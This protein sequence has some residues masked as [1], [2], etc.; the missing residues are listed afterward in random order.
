MS[1]IRLYKPTSNARRHA[2]V[3]T[4]S[5]VTAQR[6]HAS[7]TVF[8]KS[9]GGRNNQ[10]RRTAGDR[11]G[12]H[13]RMLRLV[14]FKQDKYDVPGKVESIERDPNRTGRIAL[15][16]YADGERR[17]ILA[18]DGLAVGQTVIASKKKQDIHPG[19]RLPLELIPVGELVCNVELVPGQ[20]G[21]LGRS[22]GRAIVLQGVE[23]KYAQLKLP[24]TEVRL[25]PK[26][27]MATIGGVSHSDH[28]LIRLGK[29]GRMRWLGRRPHVRGKAKNPVD[30]P[31][32]G[33]EGHN[34]IGLKHPKTP[35]G[36]PALGHPTRRPHK[37][38]DALI[39]K[40]RQRHS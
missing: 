34:P 36:K 38:S 13:R 19:V 28:R 3:D 40:P 22:A 10:G 18:P 12:G 39:I 31:H 21:V 6:P 25:V 23:G 27:A 29:A 35:T 11:G 5:D 17:Y 26:E 8:Q 4:R 2:S 7:L 24:S 1:R 37:M 20:G 30:H 14:D 32:G 33:G 16:R 15:I 9:S